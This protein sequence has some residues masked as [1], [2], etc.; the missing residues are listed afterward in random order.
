[1]RQNLLLSMISFLLLAGCGSNPN[2][3]QDKL[4]AKVAMIVS[5]ST[6][7]LSQVG[8]VKLTVKNNGQDSLKLTDRL[9]IDFYDGLSW[10]NLP[11]F[12]GILFNDVAYII[13][14]GATKELLINLNPKP[15]NYKLGKYRIIKIAEIIPG[16]SQLPLTVGFSII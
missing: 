1:M 5:P 3:S 16:K 6:V 9:S 13:P 7:K 4:Q 2:N 8:Q 14:P 11:V 15:I 10:K 12:E